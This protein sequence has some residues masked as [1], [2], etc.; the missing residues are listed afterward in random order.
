MDPL[1]LACERALLGGLAVLVTYQM[2]TGRI[3][4]K[5]ML[6]DN[7]SGSRRA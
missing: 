3:N 4:M 7:W 5:A 6:S 2:L 1:E